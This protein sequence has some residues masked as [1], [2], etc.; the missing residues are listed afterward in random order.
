MSSHNLGFAIPAGGGGQTTEQHKEGRATRVTLQLWWWDFWLLQRTAAHQ[1]IGLLNGLRSGGSAAAARCVKGPKH[2]CSQ[3]RVSLLLDVQGGQNRWLS[4]VG[5]QVG[6]SGG[7][8]PWSIK[9]TGRRELP[10]LTMQGTLFP[11]HRIPSLQSAFDN[12][13][14]VCWVSWFTEHVCF[15]PYQVWA[16]TFE[17]RT[18]VK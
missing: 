4:D 11:T 17:R 16:W 2:A 13:S 5:W 6:V 8:V 9:C 14:L 10:A 12:Y 7:H 3:E 15:S 18:N 1:L